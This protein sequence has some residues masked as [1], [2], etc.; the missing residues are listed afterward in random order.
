MTT[1]IRRAAAALAITIAASVGD[2]IPA[3][4]HR[5]SD[6]SFFA[7]AY[8]RQNPDHV[9]DHSHFYWTNGQA[10]IFNCASHDIDTRCG[11]DVIGWWQNHRIVAITGPYNVKCRQIL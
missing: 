4:A 5:E 7:C 6:V 10:T 11:Y 3:D 9:I 1:S 2:A 8:K